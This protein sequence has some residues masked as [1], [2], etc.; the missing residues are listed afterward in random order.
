MSTKRALRIPADPAVPVTSVAVTDLADYQ[1]A[2]GGNIELVEADRHSLGLYLNETGRLD[3][4][5]ENARASRL[6][7]RLQHPIVG[8]VLVLGPADD[9]GDDTNVTSELEQF[10]RETIDLAVS[11]S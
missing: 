8:D 10:V 4:L 2:V 7:R 3:G 11:G 5:R 1:A 6:A 9:D